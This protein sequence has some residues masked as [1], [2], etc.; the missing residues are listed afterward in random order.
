MSSRHTTAVMDVAEWDEKEEQYKPKD[1]VKASVETLAHSRSSK[2]PC[3]G[4][5]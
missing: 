1:N 5:L 3:H 2:K 4:D